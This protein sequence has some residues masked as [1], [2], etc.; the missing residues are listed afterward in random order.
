MNSYVEAFVVFALA[1]VAGIGTYSSGL[2]S[3]SGSFDYNTATHD[4]R[5]AYLSTVSGDINAKLR[6][7]IF[8]ERNEP[9][10]GGRSIALTYTLN[11]SSLECD[12]N[13]PCKIRQCERYLNHSV[14]VQNVSVRVRYLNSN[15][16]TLGSQLLKKSTCEQL[17]NRS[18]PS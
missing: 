13:E 12:G 9:L 16:T 6:P 18:K 14:S 17:V 3:I 11:T 2:G 10:I 4:Q 5:M 1:M 8:S 15:G 7:N